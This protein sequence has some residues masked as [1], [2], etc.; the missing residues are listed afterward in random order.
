MSAVVPAQTPPSGLRDLNPQWSRVVRAVDDD[1]IERSWHVLDTGPVDAASPTLLCVHGNPTW[2]YLWR[3]VLATFGAEHRVVAV[4]Q[5]DMGFSERTGT[6]RRLAQRVDDLDAVV[7]ALE[8][9][10][11]IV[12]VAH[13]WGGPV[14][15]GWALRHLDRLAGVV[16]TNTAVTQPPGSPAPSI[17]RLVRSNAML[18][19]TCV[20]TT[21]FIAGALAMANP[22]LSRD[23]WSGFL[24]PYQGAHRREA[25]ATFV[26]DIPLEPEHPSNDALDAIADGIVSG[27]AG[28]PTL[29]GW[30]PSD[31]VFSDLYL[32]DFEQRL[33]HAHV[34]R[35]IG[36][37][38]LVPE[39]PDFIPTLGRWLDGLTGDHSDDG[40]TPS[41]STSGVRRPLWQGLEERRDDHEVAIAEFSG[42]GET[43][44]FAE[45]H[46]RVESLAAGLLELGVA[47]GDRVALMVLPG[48]DLASTLY[49]CW[50]I[51]AVA[52]V[53]DSG[54]GARG[55][56]TAMRTATPDYLVGIPKALAAARVLRWPGEI[57]ATSS[58]DK[59]ADMGSEALA[60]GE[61]L[62]PG[63]SP[64]DLAAIVFT[65]GAT[66]PAKG[67]RY[68]HRPAEAQCAAI[69]ATY[70]ITRSDKLVAAFAPFALY[71]PA[72]GIASAVPDMDVTKP[73]TLTAEAL[74]EAVHTLD[75]SM[76][77]ASPAALANVCRSATSL[78]PERRR[79]LRD[80]RL[81]LS[82]GAPVRASLLREAA[83][84]L[85]NAEAHTPYGMTECL[86]VADI[87]LA[88]IDAAGVGNGVC[89]GLP[90]SGVDIKI[91]PIDRHGVVAEELVSTT[92]VTGEICVAAPH[93][94]DGYERL[95]ATE[96]ASS[97]NTGWHRTG[98][99][100]HLDDNGRLWVEGRLPHVIVT[101]NG[102][103]TPVAI[104]QRAESVA[105]VDMAAAVGVGPAGVQQVVVVLSG[106]AA[107]SN[108]LASA[109][110][111][112]RVRAVVEGPVAAVLT[113]ATMPTDI[114]HNSKIDRPRLATWAQNV[115]D[116]GRVGSP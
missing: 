90:V 59:L 3:S 33:P 82:A 10:G 32:H 103:V 100:G 113:V 38:H 69:M 46:R 65:S 101:S 74:A 87:E 104:E 41:T 61:V 107:N 6:V 22:R 26:E 78:S 20:R 40:D 84:L 35:F 31:P 77:F 63:P 57:I 85:G 88:D 86:P 109:E 105:G 11:P 23:V 49:A 15:L 5:L 97:R 75:A 110:L 8:I 93:R 13:D 39:H 2:S 70:G 14:S 21:G 30:G 12:V 72:M 112:D 29:L 58:L 108:G 9:D 56:S 62:P 24:A 89:V 25:I 92:G 68:L 4:D 96:A 73:A 53:A 27:L 18:R 81:L 34:H 50:R 116:G 28:V 16:L 76:V 48:I 94:K 80:V 7:D 111:T 79:A 114:R 44:S 115:L 83:E 64:D 98:D 45:L 42:A 1:G 51:G 17:I 37:S 47:P 95:W 106:P 91:A 60:A 99:V 52:V 71:G 43:M 102:V 67:V 54:L 36:A 19:A 55:L 66:G